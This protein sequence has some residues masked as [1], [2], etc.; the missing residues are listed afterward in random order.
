MLNRLFEEHAE[1]W[2]N[3]GTYLSCPRILQRRN[4]LKLR[5]MESLLYLAQVNRCDIVYAID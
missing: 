3:R 1:G 2:N 4:Y 5:A